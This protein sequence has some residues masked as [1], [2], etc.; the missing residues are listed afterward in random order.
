MRNFIWE[1]NTLKKKKKQCFVC[2]RTLSNMKLTERK[3]K[4]VDKKNTLI[5]KKKGNY[6]Y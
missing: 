5:K 3:I 1:E 6:G 4:I 2:N